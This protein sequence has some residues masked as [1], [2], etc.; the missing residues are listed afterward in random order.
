MASRE[1]LDEP[2]DVS[3]AGMRPGRQSGQLQPG[4][5]AFGA[6]LER[7]HEDGIELELHHLVEEHVRFVG[8]EPEVGGPHLHQFA[9]RTQARQRER[10][11][12]PSRHRQRDVGRQVVQQEGHRL[13]YGGPV[14]HVVVVECQHRRTGEHVEIV[15]QT[16]QGGVGRRAGAGLEQGERVDPRV[17]FNRLDRGHEVRQERPQVGVASI[18]RQPG[19][20]RPTDASHC[21]SSVVLPNPAGAATRIRRGL[22]RRLRRPVVRVRRARCTRRRRGCGGR[23]LVPSTGIGQLEPAVPQRTRARGALHRRRV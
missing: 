10:R 2:G 1:G 5:P 19:H 12:R 17:G 18:Q 7:G 11:V 21:A 22:R 23:S 9:T 14:D 4:R 8:G 15:D 16:D 20:P 6:Q 13:V 3:S